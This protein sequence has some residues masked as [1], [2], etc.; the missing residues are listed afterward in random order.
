MV[1]WTLSEGTYVTFL[2][3]PQAWASYSLS[4]VVP[5]VGIQLPCIIGFRRIY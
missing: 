2:A 3:L 5:R 4:A 1:N